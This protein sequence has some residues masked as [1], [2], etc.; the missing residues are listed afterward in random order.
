MS[1]RHPGDLDVVTAP[2]RPLGVVVAAAHLCRLGGINTI[3]MG[4]LSSN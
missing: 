1:L 4:L 2:A 3:E